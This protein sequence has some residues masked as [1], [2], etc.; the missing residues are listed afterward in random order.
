MSYVSTYLNFTN[1]TEEAF[2]FYR[3]VFG[4]EFEGPVSRFG[5]APASPDMPP[6]SDEDKNLVM[7]VCLP[8]LGG[9]KL[10][11]TDA[12]AS[13]GFQVVPG[14]NFHVSLHPDTREEAD[15]IFDG[16]SQG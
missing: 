14:N 3:S 10:M 13:M 2:D 16:L 7:H 11:G 15:R 5:D 1:R 8:I 6:L 4:G 9:H 12:P